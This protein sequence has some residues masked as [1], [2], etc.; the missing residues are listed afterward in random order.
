MSGKKSWEVAAVLDQTQKVQKE[1]F[2]AYKKEININIGDIDNLVLNISKIKQ[3]IEKIKLENSQA[4]KEF[5][6]EYKDVQTKLTKLKQEVS[7]LNPQKNN[8]QTKLSKIEKEIAQNN[9]KAQKIRDK[10]R[11]T[12]DYV[13]DEYKEAQKLK[14]EMNNLKK[15]YQNLKTE[16]TKTKQ[17][18]LKIENQLTSK[19]EEISKLEKSFQDLSTRAKEIQEIRKEASKLKEEII[20]NYRSI[21]KK[22][23]D[24]F[25]KSQYNQLEKYVNKFVNLSDKEIIDNYTKILQNISSL[26]SNIQSDYSLFLEKKAYSKK[27]IQ[28]VTELNK[29]EYILLE[30]YVKDID[31]ERTKLEYYDH[32]KKENTQKQFDELIKKAKQLFEKEKFEECNSELDKANELYT[33]ISN[34]AD[35]IKENIE[36]SFE[37]A[38]QIRDTM[39]DD[40]DFTKAEIELIDDNPINGFRINCQNG[41]TI[42]FEEV[43]IDNG[44]PTIKLDHIENTTG[45]C[46]VRWKDMV[47]VFRDKN[48]PL[49]DVTKNGI[50]VLSFERVRNKKA[51]KTQERAR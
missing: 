14:K 10:I 12:S 33:N 28:E 21:D 16:S 19:Q 35:L 46:G 8:L 37:L 32:Y 6:G 26:N 50:S 25:R 23:A 48:I 22:L 20:K 3:N 51:T 43:K 18:L 15:E 44:E 2:D 45:T 24:K 30:D 29:K 49:T 34:E 11:N 40:I 41:D 9:Q 39:L 31:S 47:K 36:S 42:N 38:L 13:N 17:S 5:A 1:I 7:N 4:Q 27:L